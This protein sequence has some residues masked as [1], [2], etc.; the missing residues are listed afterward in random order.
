MNWKEW[1]HGDKRLMLLVTAG[2][3]GIALLALSGLFAGEKPEEAD[4]PE[5]EVSVQMYEERY[6]QRVEELVR[7]IEGVG[8]AKV[9]VTLEGGVEYVYE[10]EENRSSDLSDGTNAQS[11]RSTLDRKTI[12]VEDANGHKTAL[13]RTTLEPSVRGV[14]VVCQGGGNPLVVERVTE[15][16]KVALGVP[17]TK[18]C[19]AELQG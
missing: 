12:I 8:E 18:V 13:L 4:A 10:R 19:V 17:S 11:A 15:A 6:Q 16:V 14:V 1:F 7:C 3:A 9:T 5:E 2:A